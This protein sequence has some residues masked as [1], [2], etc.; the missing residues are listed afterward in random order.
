MEKFYEHIERLLAQHDYVVIPNLG[1]FIVQIQSARI[2]SDRIAP[3]HAT[4]GFNTLMS[5]ADGLLAIEISRTE[6]ISY[7]K[8]V[9]HIDN[10]VEN[11]KIRLKATGSVII[12]DLG[13]LQKNDIG[14]LT[15]SPIYKSNFLPQNLGLS[16]LYVKTKESQIVNENRKVVIT[17]PSSRIIKYAAA[18]MLFFGLFFFSPRV[19]DMRQADY[20]NL[21][22][23]SFE[24]STKSVTKNVKLQEAEKESIDS[25]KTSE[26]VIPQVA[27]DFHVIVASLPTH[28]SA[29]KFCK[30]LIKDNFAEAHILPYSRTYR[31]AI[32]S[33]PHQEKAIEY[34]QNLRKTD[35]RFETAWVYS[36]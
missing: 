30:E 19:S 3:P 29:E 31:I 16:D 34:M 25:V 15:F 32:Q 7:R 33:F 14:S 2:L 27:N 24:N 35:T 26:T 28:S 10:E 8:A 23:I 4:I 17:M 22:S 9:E 36:K 21:A 1:G 11:I 13:I 12:G 5:H 6:Q 20:A 18:A